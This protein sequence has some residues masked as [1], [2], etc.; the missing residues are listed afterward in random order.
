MSQLK[1]VAIKATSRAPMQ[2]IDSAVVTVEKGINGDFRGSATN[3]QIT[4]LAES[5]W[6]RACE[7]VGTNL[8]WTTRRANLLVDGIEFSADDVGKKV[9]IGDVEL[10]IT[11]ET[12]PCALMEQQHQGLKSALTPNWAGGAC[13]K[14]LKAGSFKVGDRVTVA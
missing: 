1:S 10:E 5:S 14:V 12:N 8:P 9:T 4:I 11:R 7:T 6:L 13:C 2:I 3:R